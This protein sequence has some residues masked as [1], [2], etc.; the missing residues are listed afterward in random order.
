MKKFIIGCFTIMALVACDKD[1]KSTET[2]VADAVSQDVAVE[3]AADATAVA[4]SDA[5]GAVDTGSAVSPTEE[6]STT[7]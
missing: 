1:E 7:K 3:V 6:V 4:P 5:T 2:Q